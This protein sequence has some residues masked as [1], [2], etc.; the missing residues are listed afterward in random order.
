MRKYSQYSVWDSLLS[1]IPEFKNNIIN[2]NGDYVDPIAA[3]SLYNIWRTGAQ[4][5]KKNTYRKPPTVGQEEINRMKNSG[6]V[7]SFGDQIEITEKG[8]NTLKI[9]ILGDE[10]S[11]FED[12]G[13]IIDYHKALSNTKGVKTAKI[14][15]TAQEDRWWDR[16]NK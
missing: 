16:F 7:K 15:K 3:Q 10:K 12:D 2:K 13:N 5:N 1:V 14:R 11:I 6:L 4:K 9:M 8:A